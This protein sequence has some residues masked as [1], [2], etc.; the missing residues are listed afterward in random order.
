MDE[1]GVLGE[2]GADR[3][4]VVVG[5]VEVADGQTDQLREGFC[6]QLVDEVVAHSAEEEVEA[7]GGD[8]AQAGG[9][10]EAQAVDV[11]VLFGLLLVEVGV[12]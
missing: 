7:E 8:T 6:A 1:V 5:F 3:S 9:E 2:F 10:E 11:D 12:V 4:R